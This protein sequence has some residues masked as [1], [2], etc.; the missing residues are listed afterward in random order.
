M[1]LYAL[2]VGCT[3]AWLTPWTVGPIYKDMEALCLYWWRTPVWPFT[4]SLVGIGDGEFWVLVFLVM[5]VVETF[6]LSTIGTTPGKWL[7][8][9]RVRTFRTEFPPVRRALARS[10][11]VWAE[12]LALGIGCLGVATQA[13][14]WFGFGRHR[15]ALWDRQ[16]RLYVTHR[17]IGL[18]RVLVM[19]ALYAVI[20]SRTCW[21]RLA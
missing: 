2:L 21:I 10:F 17:R 1:N 4:P 13:W 15:D 16:C 12:G 5:I 6:L 3:W 11:L 9:I 8:R 18:V 7:L 20:L 14:A 19:V